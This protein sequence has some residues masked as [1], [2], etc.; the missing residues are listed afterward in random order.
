MELI[1][2]LFYIAVVGDATREAAL[3][4]QRAKRKGK[5]RAQAATGQ[6]AAC[7]QPAGSM[8]TAFCKAILKNFSSHLSSGEAERVLTEHIQILGL[9]W[10]N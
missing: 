3:Y 7:Y 9:T 6:L 8:E 4:S 1:I 5:K 2:C 10:L